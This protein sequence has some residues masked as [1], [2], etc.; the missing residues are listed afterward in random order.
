[1]AVVGV[2]L[3]SDDKLL[4][5]CG[6]YGEAEI[7]HGMMRASAKLHKGGLLPTTSE[8]ERYISGVMSHEAQKVKEKLARVLARRGAA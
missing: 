8:C 7:E 4:Y 1:M 3:P 2:P 6:R 5:W